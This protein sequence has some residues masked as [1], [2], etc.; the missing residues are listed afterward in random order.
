MLT[1]DNGVTVRLNS[2]II[3]NGSAPSGG[4]I[5]NVGTLTLNG[6]TVTGSTASSPGGGIF[7]NCGGTLVGAVAAPAPG[8][9]VYANTLDDIVNNAC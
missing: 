9:N 8:A 7:N 1:I 2:L 6:S 4:G 3:T 5:F